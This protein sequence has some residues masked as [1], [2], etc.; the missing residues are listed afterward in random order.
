M[1]KRNLT[2]SSS[3][4]KRPLV[5]SNAR[6]YDLRSQSELLKKTFNSS[7]DALFLL[8]AAIPPVVVECNRAASEIF[9]YA[10]SE[11]V[12][13]PMNF[14]HTSDES[15]RKFQAQLYPAIEK[16]EYFN[17]EYQMKRKDGSIFPSD[18]TVTSL[19]DDQE[20]RIGWISAIRDITERKRDED[21]L[22]RRAEELAALHET[23]LDITGR[24]DLPELLR[25][26]LERA[27]KLLTATGAGLYICYPEKGELRYEVSY[28]TLTE[29][30]G[31]V[32]KYGEGA[33]G[34]VAQTGE[35]LIIEDYRTWPGRAAAYEKSQ[36]FSAVLCAPMIWQN[37]TIG[38]ID[39]LDDNESRRF[40]E[41]DLKLLGLFANH[42]AIAL[43]NARHSE[44][45]ERMVAERTAKLAESQH[46]LQL[47]AD[48]LP[49]VISYVDPQQRYRFNNKAYEEWFGQ[50]PNQIIGRHVREIL[51]D[52]GYERI[53]RALRSCTLGG[54]TV[55]RI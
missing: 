54:E 45:L 55:L 16:D 53:S 10:K 14:L 6:E 8:D 44:N 41:S 20:K 38:V 4:R 2:R 30:L 9:G 50:S 3:M 33:A 46:Q 18:H 26:I 25:S 47:V 1:K 52:N 40:T 36:P 19:L 49:A 34:R 24:H 27:T 13:R 21:A 37:E 15:L 29:F 22:R 42:A 39:I 28:R 32:L 35:P 31:T 43:E 48:S 7:K 5:R 11:M 17:L 51:G 23:V 12:G